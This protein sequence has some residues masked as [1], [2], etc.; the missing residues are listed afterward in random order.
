MM[1]RLQRRAAKAYQ[2]QLD[3]LPEQLQDSR[4]AY[5]NLRSQLVQA[6]EKAAAEARA[7]SEA[8]AA[9][10]RQELESRNQKLI[11]YQKHELKLYQ[12]KRRRRMS[13]TSSKYSFSGAWMKRRNA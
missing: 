1:R 7:E 4:T 13:A 5:T 10:L 3:G 6:K 12:E 2:D 9:L 8:Q 11:E